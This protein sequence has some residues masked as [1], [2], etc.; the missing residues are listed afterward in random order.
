MQNN[1]P[2]EQKREL[3]LK[4]L[5]SIKKKRFFLIVEK[6]INEVFSPTG[7]NLPYSY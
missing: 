3:K 6:V 5:F 1:I 2:A 4:D 7:A